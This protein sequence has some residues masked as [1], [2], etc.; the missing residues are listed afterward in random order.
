MSRQVRYFILAALVICLGVGAA[1]FVLRSHLLKRPEL[2]LEEAARRVDLSLK[3][4]DYTQ[5]TDGRKE[6]TLK[7]SQVDYVQD[8]DV[9]SLKDVAVL[10]YQARGRQMKVTGDEGLYNRR[11]GWIKIVGRARIMAEGGYQLRAHSLTLSLETKEMTSS[12]QVILTGPGFQ[13][14][15]RG[16]RAELNQWRAAL[17]G[18]VA[19]EIEVKAGNQ[20]V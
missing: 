14:K 11:E 20:G 17:L 9:F 10:I 12:D 5:I 15:G 19:A 8:K 7:A 1:F 16:L 13:V 4:I 3:D 6:W 18:E 2:L